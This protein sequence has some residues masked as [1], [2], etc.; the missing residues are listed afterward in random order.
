MEIRSSKTM[1][2]VVLMSSAQGERGWASPAV[3]GCAAS[4]SLVTAQTPRRDLQVGDVILVKE[5]GLISTH[6]P[7]ARCVCREDA[8]LFR[9]PDCKT[10]VLLAVQL[11][12]P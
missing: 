12:S 6:W 5:D 11:G 8:L 2:P 1:T 7:L 3:V 4:M 9:P 10:S